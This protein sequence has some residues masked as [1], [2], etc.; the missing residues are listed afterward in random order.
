M[1]APDDHSTSTGTR[2]EAWI[3]W[4]L[5]MFL[6]SLLVAVCVGFLKSLTGTAPAAALLAGGAAFGGT[7]LLCMGI[8]P[9]VRQL[10]GDP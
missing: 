6:F 4:L 3:P 5:V 8:V 7:A 9:V 10:R 2:S 1:T